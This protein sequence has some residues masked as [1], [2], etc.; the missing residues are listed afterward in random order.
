MT[1]IRSADVPLCACPGCGTAADL[2]S[3][4]RE[5][6]GQTG[7]D[8]KPGDFTVCMTCASILVFDE[9]LGVRE[10]TVAELVAADPAML[11]Q[12]AKVQQMIRSLPGK[13]SHEK[14]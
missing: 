4:V 9:T 1:T 11:E 2:A 7:R 13:P 14:S 12:I 8:P 5:L 6:G 3:S 10:P